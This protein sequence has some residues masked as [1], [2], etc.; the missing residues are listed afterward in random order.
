M[1]VKDLLCSCC[2]Q[3]LTHFV[4]VQALPLVVDTLSLGTVFWSSVMSLDLLGSVYNNVR[5]TYII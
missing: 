3:L 5:V 4:P 2:L 1:L